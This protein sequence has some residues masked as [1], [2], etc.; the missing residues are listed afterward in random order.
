MRSYF[1]IASKEEK[2]QFRWIQE[3]FTAERETKSSSQDLQ[4]NFKVYI[5]EFKVYFGGN[6]V[7]FRDL[8]FTFEDF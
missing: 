4:R 8:A 7:Y 1:T 2:L 5:E 6:K 3:G